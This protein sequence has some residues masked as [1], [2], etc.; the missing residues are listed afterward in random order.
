MKDKFNKLYNLIMED[1][2]DDLKEGQEYELDVNYPIVFRTLDEIIKNADPK[3]LQ[4]LHKRFEHYEDSNDRQACCDIMEGDGWGV[5]TGLM[6][7]ENW[8]DMD[9]TLH[10][11]KRKY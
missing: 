7:P 2:R 3:A 5:W 9:S 6:D 11:L 8:E 10:L 4:E 1:L